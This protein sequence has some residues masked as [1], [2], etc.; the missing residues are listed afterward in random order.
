MPDTAAIPRL[1]RSMHGFGALMITLSCLSPT[2]GVFVVGSDVI[3]QAGTATF[4]CFVAAAL[5]GVAMASV[6]GELVS[7]FPETGAE[8]TILGRTMGPSW[9]FAM[10][11]MNLSG[12][13]IAQALSGLGV[14]TYL[15]VIAPG[16][17]AAPTAIA[18]VVTVTAIAMLN[19]QINALIT[20][21]FLAMEIASLAV[22][23]VLGFL[24]P[25]RA[26][27]DVVLHPVMLGSSGGLVPTSLAVMGT[28]AAGAIYAFN[29]YGGVVSLGEEMHDAPRRVAGVIFWA[30]GLAA[31]FQLVP[32]L[33]VMVGAPDL[34]AL[35]TAEAPLP[36]FIQQVGGPWLAKAM[37]L[38]VALAVFNAMIAVSLM[39]G[40]QLYSTGRDGVWSGAV[41]RAFTQIHPR[42]GSPWVATLVMG[43]LSVAWCLAPLAILVTIIACG[44]VGIYAALC[45]AVIAGRRNG[46]TAHAAYRMPFFPAAPVIALMALAGVIWTSLTDAQTGRPGLLATALVVVAS[47]LY[48][49]LVLRPRGTWGHRGPSELDPELVTESAT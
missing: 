7:A 42:L 14:A 25:H 8:Y 36:A 28:A 35:M 9:G 23:G 12:F 38:G 26:V 4:A 45:L 17:P 30:L 32:V 1:K 49:Q 41:N 40:R 24:H 15:Q 34:K 5:L 3:R 2:I 31:A 11:G 21:V 10:L 6:Y 18:L 48:Y 19:I 22:L 16:L 20:G 46:S 27:A 33:S 43:G 13:S 44:T 39:A 29:G 37:S 47:A